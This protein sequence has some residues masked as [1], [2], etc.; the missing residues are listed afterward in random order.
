[1]GEHIRLAFQSSQFDGG[2]WPSHRPLDELASV[3]SALKPTLRISA[4]ETSDVLLRRFSKL[5]NIL[6]M[7]VL[8]PTVLPF[9]TH[10]MFDGCCILEC[11]FAQ[12][13]S[14]PDDQ[15]V[16]VQEFQRRLAGSSIEN[17]A[18]QP[19]IAK[20]SIFGKIDQ[21]PAKPV[22]TMLVS[23]GLISFCAW[24]RPAADVDMK[25]R[26]PSLRCKHSAE[27]WTRIDI[28][29]FQSL[30]ANVGPVVGQSEEEGARS[31]IHA[32]TSPDME[33]TYSIDIYHMQYLLPRV[34]VCR[35]GTLLH[36][37]AALFRLPDMTCCIL[38]QARAVT[39]ST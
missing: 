14:G 17:F 6:S 29:V 25:R 30:Q 20:T 28:D 15:L 38:P 5:Y 2:R 27:H 21:Q 7:K 9:D 18:A 8:F 24:C 32:A 23:Y 39:Y 35:E 33:G 11:P 31:V 10:R 34:F 37:D 12:G 19:G 4:L 1:M 36:S 26:R 3:A 16:A 22:G 13:P